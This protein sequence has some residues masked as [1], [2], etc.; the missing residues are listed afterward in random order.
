[1]QYS[2]TL[3]L[4]LLTCALLPAMSAHAAP[5]AA[6]GTDNKPYSS[7]FDTRLTLS[8]STTLL[9]S[10]KVE[11]DVKVTTTIIPDPAHAGKTA[12]I[13][14]V[15]RMGNQFFMRTFDG[16]FLLWNGIIRDLQPARENVS[17]VNGLTVEVY[18]GKYS[19]VAQH[20]VFAGYLLDG[21]S[22]LIYTP[23][24]ALF[25]IKGEEI[26]VSPLTYF[27]D[28]IETPLIQSR[29]IACHV[30]GG[31]ARDSA[32][33]L[34]RSS[35]SSLENN[36]HTL[37][38]VLKSKGADH[39]LTKV[40][41]GNGH[42]GGVQ[43]NPG[44]AEYVN[45]A[46]M[47]QLLAGNTTVVTMPA[48]EFFADVSLQQNTDT[49]RR[50]A[51]MVAGRAPTPAEINA[52][53][54]GDENILRTTL[55]GLMSGEGFHQF[56][57]EGT[58]DRLLIE[59]TQGNIVD[60]AWS[61]YPELMQ[62]VYQI[63]L[64]GK[65]AGLSS[66]EYNAKAYELVSAFDN[67]IRASV[68]E[69]VAYVVEHDKPYTE[70]L[71]ADYMMMTPIVN[72]LVDGGATFNNPNNNP[73][74]NLEYQPGRIT[75][76]YLPD[77]NVKLVTD[78]D[79]GTHIITP[80]QRQHKWQH[81]GILNHPGFLQRYPTT[82]TNR[83]RAR[84]RWTLLNFMDID[85]EKSTQRPT[86]PIA[87]ADRNNP[88]LKNPAC[89]ACHERMD[90]VAAAFQYYGEE[91]FY[92]FNGEDS[93]DGFYK[94][95]PNG[96]PTPYQQG[97]TWYRDMRP[98]GLQGVP[99]T[100]TSEPLKDLANLIIKDPGFTRATVK[101]WWPSVMNSEV[102]LAPAVT[103]D[104]DYQARLTAY[105]A[106]AAAIEQFARNFGKDFNLKNMLADMMMSP[107]F[108]A[109]GTSRTDK[110]EAMLLADVGTEKLLTPERLQ[111]K[112][113]ALTGFNWGYNYRPVAP[114]TQSTFLGGGYRGLYGGI[115]SLAVT[116]RTR[117]ITP[118]MSSVAQTLALESA[119]PVVLKEF[120]LPD[121]KRLLFGGLDE[122]VT[123]LAQAS[124]RTE[125]TSA[126]PTDWQTISLTA[127]LNPG[128]AN[129]AVGMDNPYCDFDAI[130]KKCL[131]QRILYLDR[132]E[133]KAP[134][135]ANFQLFEITADLAK[136]YKPQ[137]YR[138]GTT[139]ALT[140][141]P[142][143]LNMLYDAK[144]SGVYEFRAVIA[145]QQAG[146]GNIRTTMVLQDTSDPLQSSSRGA[147]LI[148]QK[149]VELHS[150]LLGNN[151]ASDSPEIAAIYKLFVQT[152]QDKTTLNESGTLLSPQSCNWHLDFNFFAGLDYPGNPLKL[153]QN[154]I[155][156]EFDWANTGNFLNPKAEDP[157][158][159]KQSWVVVMAYLL[160]H[161]DYLYE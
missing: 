99:I 58:N 56:L 28:R 135:Q 37:E 131:S 5:L 33:V 96:A 41:G 7:T 139:N 134:G 87:L 11:Q 70:V 48:N 27:G 109:A 18:S 23:V 121:F 69:L 20:R 53:S 49:L 119:C 38:A 9:T 6:I 13:F 145:G 88:T 94:H 111:R 2:L 29:C 147:M 158:H 149:I 8:G 136:D 108:R 19:S 31:L 40:S 130:N 36:F 137:C 122:M 84:A 125:L 67:G 55:R 157:L 86:D 60:P 93:L 59:G 115:D 153:S 105:Q 114:F 142:C 63:K 160:G 116:K 100:N 104:L 73:N 4:L 21:S 3:R 51:I 50:A 102:L 92:F 154:G 75:N 57:L 39:I 32:M 127:N 95:P 124:T 68:N 42:G 15:E 107:W 113:K 16:R 14:I 1:M 26:S 10:A 62:S 155:S 133:V 89:T 141:A 129:L 128:V 101:F 138:S 159:V 132:F 77:G 140:F 150:K 120:M 123:P 72:Q 98:A 106:Q 35:A 44:S 22:A 152:W 112:T 76:Y 17:L 146:A 45:L 12:D 126:N 91:G 64:Q 83:N 110:R 90:P 25:E 30:I 24:P 52:V 46:T 43:L 79:L 118:M 54:S 85:I 81:V 61:Q 66:S 78:I 117:D 97:D 34:E 71:T 156:Y 65:Q 143:M 74:N 161:Y 151:Y 148:K 47:L 82:A 80:S 144:I 103:S